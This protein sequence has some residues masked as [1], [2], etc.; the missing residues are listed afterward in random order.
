[1]T[2]K[3]LKQIGRVRSI[4]IQINYDEFH[5]YLKS[6]KLDTLVEWLDNSDGTIKLLEFICSIHSSLKDHQKINTYLGLNT[7]MRLEGFQI[8]S[9]IFSI[10][11]DFRGDEEFVEFEHLGVT[12]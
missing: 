2:K 12:Q 7:S 5:E 10:D 9:E 8:Q 4:E 11:L 6:Q 1:M 3:T